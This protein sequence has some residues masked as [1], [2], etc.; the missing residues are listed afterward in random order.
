LFK[1]IKRE[2]K[3]TEKENICQFGNGKTGERRRKK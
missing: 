1:K 3:E 2:E